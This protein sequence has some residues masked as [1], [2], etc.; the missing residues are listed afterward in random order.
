MLFSKFNEI[1]EPYTPVG[2]PRN[3]WFE[4]FRKKGN[5][6]C[7]K[8]HDVTEDGFTQPWEGRDNYANPVFEEIFITNMFETTLRDFEKDPEHTRFLII[9]PEWKHA[10]W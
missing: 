3:H 2:E 6:I 4:L 1:A 8:G 5:E 7:S 9:V 10:S